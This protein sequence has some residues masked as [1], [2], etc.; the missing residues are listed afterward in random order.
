MSPYFFLSLTILLATSGQIA[1]KQYYQSGRQIK[2]LMATILFFVGTPV[3]SYLSL[4]ELPLD[5]VYV[6]TSVNIL[7]ILLASFFYFKEQI[8]LNRWLGGVTI[9]IGILIYN[10]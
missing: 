6:S 8:P 3:C 1:Y 5:V 4:R 2:Y 9:A 7:L 10:L